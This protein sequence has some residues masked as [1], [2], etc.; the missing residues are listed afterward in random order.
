M[1]DRRVFS[2]LDWRLVF[3]IL[4]LCGVGV[5]VAASSANV[6]SGDTHLRQALWVLAGLAA[7]F[8][9]ASLDYKILASYALWLYFA[10]NLLL[11]GLLLFGRIIAGTGRWFRIGGIGFQP[12]ELAKVVLIL[13]LALIFSE[14]KKRILS[15]PMAG[16]GFALTLIP[17]ALVM[18]QPDLGT[19]AVYFPIMLAAFFLAG[20]NRKAV[21]IFLIISVALG[22]LGWGVFLRD[23]QKKRLT[24]L[25]N[26]SQ[27]PRGAGYQILQSKIAV[28]SG[29]LTGKGFASGSQ[30]QLRFLPARHTDF[31]FSV[32]GEEFGFI[33]VASV[34]MLFGLFFRRIFSAAAMSRDRMGVYIVFMAGV[35]I[36]FQF[37]INILMVIGFFP[38]TGIPLPFISYGGSSLVSNG[39]A[40]GL[41]LNVR[42]RRFANV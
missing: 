12:S 35:M 21:A 24:T 16:L 17:A 20:L 13:V 7:M 5:A 39:L 28:G 37:F 6:I 23:Y 15:V 33:G 1:I 26:P 38:V 14:Y 29:G 4:L 18:L 42:M 31:V 34:M 32:I 8:L 3:I 10:V 19:A 41:I 22:L 27:D 11:V 25:I 9:A 40:C 36:A 2:E 30:I